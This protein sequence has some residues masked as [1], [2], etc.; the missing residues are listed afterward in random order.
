MA[1]V[2]AASA[3]TANQY[4]HRSHCRFTMPG[5]DS[6][7]S[8]LI[9]RAAASAGA[10]PPARSTAFSRRFLFESVFLSSVDRPEPVC[11]SC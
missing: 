6:H 5:G 11:W 4:R 8:A 2:S 1:V 10:N 3:L 9:A 7:G